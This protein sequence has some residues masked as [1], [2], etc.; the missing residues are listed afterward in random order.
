MNQ[1]VTFCKQLKELSFDFYTID[2]SHFAHKAPVADS[3]V[4]IL[5]TN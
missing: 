5:K 1:K 4:S 2:N 3:C